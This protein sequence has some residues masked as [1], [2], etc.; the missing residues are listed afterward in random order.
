MAVISQKTF[1]NVFSWMKSFVF[2]IRIWLKF[3]T[4]GLIDNKPLSEPMLIKFTNVNAY[5]RH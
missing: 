1:S 4:K 3:V 5:M 2:L